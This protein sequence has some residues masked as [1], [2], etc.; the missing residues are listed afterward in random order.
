MENKKIVGFL[1][2]I[3]NRIDNIPVDP[4]AD[5]RILVDVDLLIAKIDGFIEAI[6]ETEAE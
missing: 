6:D 3:R 2:E 1:K 4:V 5:N